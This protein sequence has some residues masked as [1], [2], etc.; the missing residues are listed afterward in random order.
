MLITF[1]ELNHFINKEIKGILHIGAHECEEITEYNKNGIESDNIFWV[2]GMIDKV[3][4]M[5]NKGI[6]NIY[7]GLIDEISG[8]SVTFNIANNGQSSSILSFG[9]HKI[10]HPQVKMKNEYT[11]STIRLDHL[12]EA[13]GIPIENLNFINLDIQGV[14]LRAL[15]SME[16]YLRNID[17][18]YTE[19]NTEYVYEN[20]A[21]LKDIDTY[22]MTFGFKRVIVKM[23]KNCGWGDAFYVRSIDIS[24]DNKCLLGPS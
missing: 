7:H 9:T 10:H 18:I 11:I 1:Q 17:Y 24:S 5:K 19:V 15:K 2:E 21:L 4:Q 22:L 12:I 8:K 3:S 6:K 23:W 13:N 16:K 14:E 20:C